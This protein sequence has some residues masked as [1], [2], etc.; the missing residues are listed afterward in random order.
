MRSGEHDSPLGGGECEAASAG[1]DDAGKER[2]AARNSERHSR[3]N[4]RQALLR[5]GISKPAIERA[6]A[7][8]ER[9]GTTIEQELLAE[10]GIDERAYYGALARHLG[11]P[12]LD[13]I[14]AARVVNLTQIEGQ[15]ASPKI[16]RLS[17]GRNP[18]VAAVVP[19]AGRLDELAASIRT[20]PGLARILVVTRPA[21]IRAA[22]WQARSGERVRACVRELFESAPRFS[23]RTV[24][25]GTQGFLLGAFVSGF[26]FTAAVAEE[27][28]LVLLHLG[29]SL[30]YLASL[31]LRF[32]AL[33]H[34]ARGRKET[35]PPME[36]PYPVYTVMVALYREAG[37]A[38][39]LLK[40]LD[41]LDWPRS[42]LDI[43][44]VC[45]ADDRDTIEALKA[46]KPGPH[47]E[48]VEVP[49]H[50]PRTKPK[51]LSYAL[52]AA[53]GTYLAI[54]DAEDRP[55]PGQLKEACARFRSLPGDV[56]CLQ[57]PLIVTN[58][59]K[60]HISALFA[61]EYA[62]L[63]RRLLPFLASHCLPLPLGGTSNHFRTDVLL[64]AG[65]WDPYNVTE[66]A[67]LG[68]RLFRLG[69]RADVLHRQTLE[70][71]PVSLPVWTRQRTRWFKGWLQTWLVATRDYWAGASE[72]GW[73]GFAAFHLLFGG[74]LVSALLHPAIL[75]FLAAA[76]VSMAQTPAGTHSPLQ[77]VLVVIDVVNIVGAY[78]GFVALGASPM[79]GHEKKLIGWRWLGVPLYWLM[80]SFAAWRAVFELRQSPFFW[81][82]TPH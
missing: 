16:L 22:V 44:L 56:A 48:I 10:C 5:L 55:H 62:A 60:S 80:I 54:F 69:Y 53:R 46:L 35:A 2:A 58:G 78:A 59:D 27:I 14:D 39:Q 57:A 28:L 70:E 76:A 37:I 42:R 43:K 52:S 51:A 38:P 4:E 66:D 15:L 45:E 21:A 67:D 61:L 34:A 63:F 8:S 26:L 20:M 68:L 1:P 72:M 29:L 64:R 19:E 18:P 40:A 23:A 12:Y 75:I 11:L 17:D 33:L 77:L 13:S 65:G 73:S 36:G 81:H 7:L 82:K 24:L 49:D 47:Y 30:F 25:S 6:S 71:A 32:A 41:R 31:S 79:T 3:A 74:V 50:G 9:H